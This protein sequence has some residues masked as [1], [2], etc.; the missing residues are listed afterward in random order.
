MHLVIVTSILRPKMAASVF[1]E[2]ERFD[3]LLGSIQSAQSK[4]P[5]CLIVVLEGSCFTEEQTRKVREN[6]A[7]EVFHI[8]IDGYQKSHGECM[9]L[10][11]FL[12][13][14][15]FLRLR[16]KH[17][18]L[19]I[20]KLSGRYFFTQEFVFRYDGEMCIAKI[21]ESKDSYSGHGMV[22]TR[23]YSI[24]VRYLEHFIHGLEQS[25]QQIFINIE[26]S[27]YLHQVIPLNKIDPNAQKINV[28]GF[29]APN[30]E[31]V[32]D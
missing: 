26:H 21:V 8:N 17:A 32:E 5:D 3:Q 24:P 31:Y 9:L 7:R 6:G 28:A 22:L 1:S 16:Q 11:T 20:N 14:E 15:P 30:G 25:C 27:F 23:F 29:I 13:S 2:S 19:S 10:K 12:T 4:I 18:F